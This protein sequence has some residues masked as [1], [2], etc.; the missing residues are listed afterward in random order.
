MAFVT[1]ICVTVKTLIKYVLAVLFSNLNKIVIM[2]PIEI[3]KLARE[4]RKAQKEF[5]RIRTTSNLKKAK[6]LEASFDKAVEE[7]LNPNTQLCFEDFNVFP[8]L[9]PED[10]SQPENV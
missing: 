8:M 7:F 1:S 6:R 3:I 4:M 10:S 5:F 2:E 9:W